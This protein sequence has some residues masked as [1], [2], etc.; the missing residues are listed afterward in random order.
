M[1]K[2]MVIVM[3]VL[4]LVGL[5]IPVFSNAEQ[6]G[7]NAEMWVNCED[8]KRLNVR[9]APSVKAKILYRVDSGKKVEIVEDAG[10]GWAKVYQQGKAVGYV[11][12]QFL[13]AKKPGKYEIT[14]RDDNFRAVI[15]YKVTALPR[16]K[17]TDQSVGLRTRPNKTAKS[18]RR[19]IAG[20]TLTVVAVGRTWSK[21][22]DNSTGQTGFVANDYIAKL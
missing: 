2:L 13:H 14:E 11:K 10:Y 7:D 5:M 19:L 21:V 1:K 4:M 8:G 9:E 12:T 22:V 16:G 15:S 6:V 3:V 18:I 20:D 17:N